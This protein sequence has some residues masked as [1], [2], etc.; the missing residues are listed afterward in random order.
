VGEEKGREGKGILFI[1]AK[2]WKEYRFY[3]LVETVKVINLNK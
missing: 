1:L 2:Y 3:F